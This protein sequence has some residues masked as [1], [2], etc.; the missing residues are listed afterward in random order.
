MNDVETIFQEILEGRM[1]NEALSEANDRTIP[2]G[3][4]KLEVTSKE[5]TSA[6]DKSPWPGRCMV[7]VAADAYAKLEDGTWKKK[8]KIFFDLSPVEMRWD[9]GSL[10]APAK[11]WA[12]LAAIVGKQ[13]SNKE[14]YEYLGQYP[15]RGFVSRPFKTVEGKYVTPKTALDEKALIESGAE[16][17]NFVNNLGVFSG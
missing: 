8:G 11:L 9:S 13:A 14:I 7:K 5:L 1:S 4:Y 15:V 3:S 17:K 6:G 10:D 12:N 2:S 16:P